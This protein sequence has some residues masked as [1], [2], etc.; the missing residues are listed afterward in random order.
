[1]CDILFTTEVKLIDLIL[2]PLAKQANF[3]RF[4][5]NDPV[6]FEPY[7]DFLHFHL[8]SVCVSSLTNGRVH[9]YTGVVAIPLKIFVTKQL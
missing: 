2:D 7:R 5:R 3:V 8:K 1:M 4:D 6:Q 9:Q